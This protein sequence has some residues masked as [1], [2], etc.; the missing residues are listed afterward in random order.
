MTNTYK[1]MV[2]EHRHT[3]TTKVMREAAVAYLNTLSS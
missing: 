3:N 1:Q 2:D